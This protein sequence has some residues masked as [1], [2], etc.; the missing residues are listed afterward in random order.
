MNKQ[1]RK[2]GGE[3]EREKGKK[4]EKEEEKEEK[5]KKSEKSR[6]RGGRKRAGG[7]RTPDGRMCRCPPGP[8]CLCR[9][10]PMLINNISSCTKTSLLTR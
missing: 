5:E 6:M 8:F 2:K 9:N 10:E 7:Q 1:I 4:K 3:R